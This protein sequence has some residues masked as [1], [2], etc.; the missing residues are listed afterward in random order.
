LVKRLGAGE[1]KPMTLLAW[2]NYGR[3]MTP[4]RRL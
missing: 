4:A 2:E 1:K 3:G